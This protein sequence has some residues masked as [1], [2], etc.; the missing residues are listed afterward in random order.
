M[1]IKKD[2]ILALDE[3]IS[4]EENMLKA[5]T[6]LKET[7]D[8]EEVAT[9]KTSKKKEE[10]AVKQEEVK[11]NTAEDIKYSFQDVR[12]LMAKLSTDGKKDEVK[13]LLNK[14]GVNRLSE[15]KEQDYA[16]LMTKAK[17]LVNG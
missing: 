10:K 11:E 3:I 13:A 5:L 2:L 12:A 1:T 15:V 4:A 9:V 7:L 16:S 14:F 17:E 8:K 6:S